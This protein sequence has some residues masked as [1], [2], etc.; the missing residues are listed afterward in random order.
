MIDTVAWL[1]NYTEYFPFAAFVGLLLAGLN[2][3]LSEDLI[4][5]TGAL[6]SRGAH[7]SRGDS[8]VLVSTF[9]AIYL[10][11]VI[12]DYF[13]YYFGILLRKGTLKSKFLIRLFSQKNLDKMHRHLEKHAFL[14][15][16]VCRFIPFG[17]RNT[18]LLTSGFFGL[19]LRRFAVYEIMA[20]T[21]SVSTLFF[22]VYYFGE[23]LK[24]PYHAV[25]IILFILIVSAAVF[26][27][28]GIIREFIEKRKNT[29]K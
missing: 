22:L 1:T 6:I 7:E 16:I 24:K 20:A 2:V 10:G 4:I 13:P 12:S 3:P 17:V 26:I 29:Q 11:V 9:V 14:T 27:I 8:S 25:G 28:I 15:F 18:L 5:I 23:A 19:Q 21:I